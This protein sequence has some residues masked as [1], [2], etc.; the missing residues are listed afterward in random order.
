MADS[1]KTAIKP[2]SGKQPPPKI[3][4]ALFVCFLP[5]VRRCGE[6]GWNSLPTTFFFFFFFSAVGTCYVTA[7]R[8]YMSAPRTKEA[9]L[10]TTG[11]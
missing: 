7:G 3:S 4:L 11:F 10:R 5:R 1:S 8:R 6:N 2:V 9:T